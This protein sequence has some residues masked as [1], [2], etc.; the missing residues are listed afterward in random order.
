LLREDGAE[1]PAAASRGSMFMC[2]NPLD[3]RLEAAL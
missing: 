1:A 3:A 2:D